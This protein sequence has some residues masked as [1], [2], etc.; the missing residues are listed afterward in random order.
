MQIHISW[1]ALLAGLIFIIGLGLVLRTATRYLTADD[2]ATAAANPS[3]ITTDTTGPTA[4]AG[5]TAL[6]GST[7]S[8]T[9][10]KAPASLTPVETPAA[11][12]TGTATAAATPI[13]TAAP[14]PTLPLA[15]PTPFQPP[16]REPTPAPAPITIIAQ[17][18]GQRPAAMSY[19]FVIANPNPGLLAQDIRYQV[20]MYDA[21]GIVL[22][23]ETG[24]IDQVGPGQQIGV[25]KELKLGP[26]LVVARI[27]VLLRPGQFVQAPPLQLLQVSN[28]A[29]V[30][31]NPPNLTGILAN[32]LD[33]DLANLK[34]VGIAFN[35]S[36][37]IGGGSVELPFAPAGRQVPISVPVVT[38]QQPTRI[39]FFA[40]ISA[41]P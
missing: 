34:I 2:P 37:I 25:G 18:F 4:L 32:P 10:L 12:A 3:T 40:P 28:P 26:N 31:G 6:P 21:S 15:S 17:G 35:D 13:A 27:D 30:D 24:T 9:P 16:T 39:E 20:A 8:A 23:T 1:K 38:S 5:V 36:G 14:V 33:R 11:T 29:F 19:A 41:A 22:Q 7:A